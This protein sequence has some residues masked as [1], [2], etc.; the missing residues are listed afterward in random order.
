LGAQIAVHVGRM[1]GLA[2]WILVRPL[3]VLFLAACASKSP[4]RAHVAE[5]GASQP[6][7]ASGASVASVVARCPVGDQVNTSVYRFLERELQEA[8]AEDRG[9]DETRRLLAEQAEL[10][11]QPEMKPLRASITESET[12]HVLE[13]LCRG[14]SG[15][16]AVGLYNASGLAIALSSL[17]GHFAPLGFEDARWAT[18]ASAAADGARLAI[19]PGEAGRLAVDKHALVVFRAEH[20]LA[21]CIVEQ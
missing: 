4:P 8:A 3:P 2:R 10:E 20:G 1:V 11:N 12:S 21:L 19:T 6:S 17:D 5:R 14:T 9:R 16:K 7:G 15:C 13:T 18:L